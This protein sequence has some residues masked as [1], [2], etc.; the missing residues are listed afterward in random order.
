M[1]NLNF[2]KLKNEFELK[3]K[4]ESGELRIAELY[5]FEIPENHKPISK[6]QCGSVSILKFNKNKNIEVAL[7]SMFNFK[8]TYNPMNT[9]QIKNKF[10][11]EFLIPLEFPHWSIVNVFN[12][13]RDKIKKDLFEKGTYLN[14]W[15]KEHFISQWK[16]V[17][18][19]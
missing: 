4:F 17:T 11:N 13:F 12:F 7:K 9:K 2:E 15:M 16:N 6:G 18:L 3:M 10:E 8:E 14:I 1:K 19:I 5:D